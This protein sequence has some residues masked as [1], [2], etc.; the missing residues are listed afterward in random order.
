MKV[1]IW[2]DVRKLVRKAEERKAAKLPKHEPAEQGK[3]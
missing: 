3:N 1:R 2:V